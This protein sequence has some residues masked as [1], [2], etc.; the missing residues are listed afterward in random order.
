[1][2]VSPQPDD[3][4]SLAPYYDLI[5]AQIGLT[6]VPFYLDWAARQAG[7]DGSATI[8]ELGCGTGRV[9]LPLARAGHSVVALDI[10]P[11]MLDILRG[12]LAQEPPDVQACVE[13]VKEDMA[14]FDLP[15]GTGQQRQFQLILA[16]FRAF[17]HLLE[18]EQQRACLT[19]IRAHM[20]PA[21]AYIHDQFEPSYRYVIENMQRGLVWQ[22][23]AEVA[24]PDGSLL[25]RFHLPRY[26]LGRQRLQVDFRLDEYGPDRVLRRSMLERIYLRLTHRQEIL[27]LLEL[28]GLKAIESFGGFGGEQLGAEIARELVLVCQ[29]A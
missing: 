27:Y 2:P 15:D 8:L 19:R 1:M 26:E 7:S 3:Y 20:G 12:K 6:D 29:A 11:A 18:P 10:S 5:Y 13:V 17:Q 24:L 16:P 4:R 21:G 23:D 25:Q 22:H 28:C 9:T 14:Q